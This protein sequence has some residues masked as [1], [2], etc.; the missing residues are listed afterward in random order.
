MLVFKRPEPRPGVLEIEPYVPG[1]NTTRRG[2]TVFKPSSNETPLGPRPQAVCA[3][4]EAVEHLAV[5]PDGSCAA[6]RFA[7]GLTYNLNPA[8]V[9]CAAGSGDCSSSSLSVPP[10]RPS[11]H[12]PQLACLPYRHLSA[13]GWPIVVPEPNY[14][15]DV[16]AILGAV[17][18]GTKIVFLR[19]RMRSRAIDHTD[20]LIKPAQ[21]QGGQA[22]YL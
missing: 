14:T 18:P 5:Y 15:A 3:Y 8:L 22:V 11:T 16:D 13:G 1:G 4:H 10:T 2:A 6:L 19:P 7:I 20:G 17:T 9:V 12:R 21:P